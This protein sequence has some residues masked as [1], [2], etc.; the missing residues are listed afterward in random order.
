MWIPPLIWSYVFIALKLVISIYSVTTETCVQLFWN[1]VFVCEAT[2]YKLSIPIIWHLA[3]YRL[4]THRKVQ[5][6]RRQC[7][8]EFSCDYH[9]SL[10]KQLG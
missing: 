6:I 3:I 2:Q 1:L 9:L 10:L 4:S 5:Q 8:E 7:Y